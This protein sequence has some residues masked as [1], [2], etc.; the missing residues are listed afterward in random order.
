MI[1]KIL[2]FVVILN[3]QPPIANQ[4]HTGI[5]HTSSALEPGLVLPLWGVL[6]RCSAC[7]GVCV[8]I[9]I[10]VC[11]CCWCAGANDSRSIVIPVSP[12]SG[13]KSRRSSSSGLCGDYNENI[14]I[15]F[16]HCHKL[17]AYCDA[18]ILQE[19]ATYRCEVDVHLLQLLVESS[20]ALARTD[21]RGW[22][23]T[24]RPT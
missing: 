1:I 22:Y 17:I 24:C 10:C 6:S 9:C 14:I 23:G 18:S 21:G 19:I 3:A 12:P 2:T 20:A 7:V 15:V 5:M 8:C 4:S 13:I 11:I 16:M